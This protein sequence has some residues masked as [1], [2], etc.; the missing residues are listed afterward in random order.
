MAIQHPR[1]KPPAAAAPR[2]GF[3]IMDAAHAQALFELGKLSAL[4]AR[5]RSHGADAQARALAAEVGGFFD[6]YGREHHVDEEKHV[7]PRLLD[8]GDPETVQAVHCLLQ[9]HRWL[10]EDWREVGAQ[11]DA[12][13]SGQGWVNPDQL[14][15]GVEIFSGLLH[16]HIA[17]EEAYIYPQA[18]ANLDQRLRL[19]MGREIAARH[20]AAR[21]I[22]K[23]AAMLDAGQIDLLRGKLREREASLADLICEAAPSEEEQAHARGEELALALALAELKR[24]EQK[25]VQAALRRIEAGS[26][27]LCADCG[28]SILIS[29]LL[30]QPECL[31]CTGC[32]AHFEAQAGSG[33]HR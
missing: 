30:T 12:V 17:F 15:E 2:D 23:G 29:R 14:S 3:E 20:R 21:G 19:E 5:L 16:A 7:F 18:R 22:P 10:D 25:D 27:G 26:Y 24:A 9:D 11:V 33:P 6:A 13:A 1:V 8:E 32:Q 4:V 28:E 31:R